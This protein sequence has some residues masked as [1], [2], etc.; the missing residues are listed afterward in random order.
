MI[1]N[2]AFGDK[3]FK[4]LYITAGHK[5]WSIRTNATGHVEWLNGKSA[6]TPKLPH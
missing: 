5:L 6:L 1:T 4:T 3:D 2:C